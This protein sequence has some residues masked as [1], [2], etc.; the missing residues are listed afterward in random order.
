MVLENGTRIR[1]IPMNIRLLLAIFLTCCALPS[2]AQQLGQIGDKPIGIQFEG[3]GGNWCSLPPRAIVR[4]IGSRS[5]AFTF[6]AC[7]RIEYLAGA[8]PEKDAC[9]L[10]AR[11]W[12][13]PEVWEVLAKNRQSTG[14]TK[15]D[16]KRTKK[17]KG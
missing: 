1:R 13:S 15:E 11:G 5:C 9:P 16:R 17:K 7:V 10:D 6:D 2:H 12:I 4:Q 14:G 8:S 3:G